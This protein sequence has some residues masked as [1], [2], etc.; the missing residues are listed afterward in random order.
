M[1][2]RRGQ[3][4]SAVSTALHQA[5][6]IP[7]SGARPKA[8]VYL[9]SDTT[10]SM[11]PVIAAVQAGVGAVVGNPALSGFDVA[12]VSWDGAVDCRPPG[13][14]C[15]QARPRWTTVALLTRAVRLD[16]GGPHPNG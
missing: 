10:G 6:T 13:S 5:V 15:G 16:H 1:D 2:G 12:F 4:S 3:V 7:V 14:S 9:L 8:D 11:S